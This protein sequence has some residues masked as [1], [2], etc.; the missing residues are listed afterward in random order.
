MATRTTY[1]VE[2]IDQLMLAPGLT[3]EEIALKNPAGATYFVD[4][5]GNEECADCGVFGPCLPWCGDGS[6]G[7]APMPLGHQKW[8]ILTYAEASPNGGRAR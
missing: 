6:G 2:I 3:D 7:Y 4:G 5:S 8:D 1:K